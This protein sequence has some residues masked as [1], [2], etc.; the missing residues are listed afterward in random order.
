MPVA[1]AK[2]STPSRPSREAVSGACSPLMTGSAGVISTT[3][4]Y[5]GGTKTNPTDE[6]V[7]SGKTGHAEALEVRL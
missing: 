6:E 3:P 7:L 4:G 5:T 1:N 2:A